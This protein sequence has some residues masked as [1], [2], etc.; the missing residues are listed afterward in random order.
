MLRCCELASRHRVPTLDCVTH[1]PSVDA[2]ANTARGS[3]LSHASLVALARKA[4]Q[5]AQVDSRGVEALFEE[6]VHSAARRRLQRVINATGVLIHTN[7]GRS[8][9]RVDE[10]GGALNL[11]FELSTGSRGVRGADLEERLALL[12][13]AGSAL[14]V[15]NGAAA[16]ILALSA[17]ATGKDVVISRGELVEI[18]GGFRL[19]EVML[20]AGSRLVEVGTTNKTHLR[21]YQGGLADNQDA[22]V[23]KVH[24]SNF[25][26]SGFVSEVDLPSLVGLGAPTV[27]D[28]GSG[29]LDSRC[30][31]LPT[32]PPSWLA[33]EPTVREC[34]QAGA[35]LTVFSGDKL[36][37]GPQAGILVGT[38][39]LIGLC[40]AHP[41]FRAFRCGGLIIEALSR[42]VDAYL[43]NDG[44]EIGFW[45]Q[46]GS[47]VEN[48]RARAAAMGLFDVVE[49]KSVVGGGCLPGVEIDS[50]GVGINGD[51][52]QW[53][54][55]L[56]IPIV[57][58]VFEGCTIL[59]L[60][61][62]EPFDDAVLK[63]ALLELDTVSR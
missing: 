8:P 24:R 62:V 22:V 3:G 56:E 5:Q 60:R 15:N 45:R 40:R 46:A 28:L 43:A 50:V 21:D 30:S 49:T 32:S 7:L 16:L 53:L 41:L 54:L 55:G 26:M 18:G 4:I 12:C 52:R 51:H 13:G 1:P 2:L 39:E 59:D 36:F 58:R 23:L 19:P 35:G 47:T 57:A 6:L 25:T 17:V 10:L 48:L 42:T 31:W 9:V 11:E 37:G 14:V 27:M 61:T 38:R 20:Q 29:L 33:G 63:S 44:S 34:V